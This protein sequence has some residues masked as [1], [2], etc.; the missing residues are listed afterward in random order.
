MSRR[1]LLVDDDQKLLW[2]MEAFFRAQGFDVLGVLDLRAAEDALA[3]KRFDL[4]I[5]DLRLVES[6]EGLVVVSATRRGWPTTPVILLT[7]YAGPEISAIAV[8]LGATRVLD[9]PLP[10]P[11]L[12]AVAQELMDAV[13]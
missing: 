4:V 12:L 9:K 2:A 8:K 3:E 11:D 10:L 7:A 5:T 13:S 1:L 6:E